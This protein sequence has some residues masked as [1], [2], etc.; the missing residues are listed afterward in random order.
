MSR[1]TYT[2]GS[3][4]E[5]VVVY[6][7]DTKIHSHHDTDPARGQH[8]AFDLVRIH[9]FGDQDTD[10]D[11][12]LPITERPSYRAMCAFALEQPEIA[13]LRIAEEFDDLGPLPS[14]DTG[15]AGPVQTS[16]VGSAQRAEV[17]GRFK[18]V[19]PE[20]FANG[21]ALEWIV[22][23]ILPKAELAVV[24]GESGS[25]KT[26]K[27]FDLAAAV[28][29]GVPWRDRKV[30]QG[31]VVYVCAEGG[32]GF[33]LRMRAY[34]RRHNVPL[35]MLP[36]VISDVPH[37]LDPTHVAAI[38]HEIKQTGGAS[39]IVI[40]TLA[41]TTPGANENA[42]EDMGKA[43]DHC[44][45][46]HKLTDGALVVLVHHSGKDATKGARGWS[47]LKGAIDA[48]IEIKRVGDFRTATITK[49]KDGADGASF[50]FKLQVVSLGI[51]E[52]GDDITSCVIEH[53]DE[54]P[55]V[56][57]R[58]PPLKGPN[59][60]L[61]MKTARDVLAGG[62]TAYMPDFV[63]A[64]VEGMPNTAKPG[65]RDTRKQRIRAAIDA[66]VAG[67]W[68]HVHAHD[69]ISMTTAVEATEDWEQ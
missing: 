66:L 5:G 40:D 9:L 2:K 3:R 36:A 41:A 67:G 53:V 26:F 37:L 16:A 68:L 15:L 35:T 52:D 46:L 31:R 20:E 7:D 22:K 28:S 44:K 34:A 62:K 45:T 51:D 29:R 59:Q 64:C 49:M 4:P 38:A 50:P 14:E 54:T 33:A 69:T 10:A 24:Y 60:I 25:G 18:V 42:G 32:R 63:D 61:V 47:G 56:R 12:K 1:W 30:R 48:E 55:A 58:R 39:L 21:P 23:G 17:V 57:E 43:I 6:D 11:L 19:P 13:A 27:I 65:E 8:N